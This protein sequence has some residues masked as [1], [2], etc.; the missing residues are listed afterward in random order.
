MRDKNFNC[1]MDEYTENRIKGLT[2]LF[3]K[4]QADVLSIA[5]DLLVDI[6]Q[7]IEKGRQDDIKEYA[8]FYI[9]KFLNRK[10]CDNK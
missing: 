10:E 3:N 1:R 7:Y 4:S 2:Q 9:E 8:V 6:E 5:I